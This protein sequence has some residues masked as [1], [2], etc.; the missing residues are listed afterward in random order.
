MHKFKKILFIFICSIILFVAI[1]IIFISPIT[2]YLVEKYDEKYTGRQITMDWAYV[3]PFTGYINFNDLKIY[4]ENSDS[5]FFSANNVSANIAIYKFFNK[6]F[7]ISKITLD[8]PY[9]IIIKNE[10]TLNFTDLIERYS[11][12]AEKKKDPSVCFNILDINII[13]AV[14]HFQDDSSAIDYFIKDVNIISAGKK[15]EVDTIEAKISFLSGIGTGDING[16]ITVNFKNLDYHFNAVAHKFDLKI[17]EQYLSVL[18]NYG[19]FKANIDAN[20]KAF[21]NFNDKETIDAKGLLVINDFH[22]GKDSIEDYSS[23]DKFTLFVNQLNPKKHI[24]LVD[25]ASLQHPYFKFERY[26]NNLDNIQTMFG[27]NGA[28]VATASANPEK[29][30]LII[31]IAKYVKVLAKN[32][33]KSNYKI[34][35]LAIYNGDFKYNDYTLNEKFSV[36]ANP[37]YAYADSINKSNHWVKAYFKSGLKPYGNANVALRINPK[38]SSDF[39]VSYHISKVPTALFNPYLIKY[40]SFPLD[41]GTI[42]L[43]GNWTVRNDIISS[44]NHLIVID[45]RLSE[46]IMNEDIKWVPMRIIMSFVRERGNVID[47]QIPITGSLKNPNFNLKDVLFDVLENIFVKPPTTPYRMEVKNTEAE[48]EKSLSLKWQIR[49]TELLNNQ[50]KFIKQMAEFLLENNNASIN[51]YPMQYAIKEKEYILLFE[52]K[53]KY[54]L[55]ANNKTPKVFTED[56]SIQV[57]QMSI[58][59]SLFVRYLNKHVNDTMKIFTIQGKCALII[60]SS[61]VNNK[62]NQQNSARKKIFMTYFNEKKVEKQIK[63]SNSENTIPYNGFSFYK[64]AYKGEFPD[65]LKKA[66]SQMNKLNSKIPR[67]RFKKERKTYKNIQ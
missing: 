53:K 42:E 8:R 45:P 49:N 33:F 31:E 2:K 11:S 23:F 24:Y 25:S 41:R 63:F 67:N 44:N 35:R 61:T 51:V 57:V 17:I 3:N 55:I 30:N 28:N 54:F 37:I 20:I 19:S 50:E 32:F 38:D 66:Y 16:N 46:R 43:K 26:D 52:A 36:D 21:G 29:F 27:K 5:I 4:E 59:D 13:N 9:G 47:Y 12:K 58:H 40:T 34:N 39:D 6:T 1:I 10:K 15:W 64:I 22:F 7:E 62:F 56:D 14:I 48:I 65:A 60:D 18:I